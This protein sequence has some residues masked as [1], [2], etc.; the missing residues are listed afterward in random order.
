MAGE[1]A[2]APTRSAGA[3]S[4][5]RARARTRAAIE[6]IFRDALTVARR[7]GS[8]AFELRAATR[9]ARWLRDH[10]RPAAAMS[11]VAAARSRSGGP[12][13][14]AFRSAAAVERSRDSL[15]AGSSEVVA[16]GLEPG[17]SCM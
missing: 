14:A 6:T 16:P 2:T 4:C 8:K 15:S 9:F 7:Q 5:A 1:E 12:A 13:W 3:P 10:G 17:A 11:S